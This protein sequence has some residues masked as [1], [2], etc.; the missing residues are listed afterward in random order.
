MRRQFDESKVFCKCVFLKKGFQ[1]F[2]L[3]FQVIILSYRF[4]FDF[5]SYLMKTKFSGSMV[6]AQAFTALLC[7][8]C[9][10]SNV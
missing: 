8:F 7:K 2:Y 5:L 6:S 1:N 4:K 10:V 3:I 9:S